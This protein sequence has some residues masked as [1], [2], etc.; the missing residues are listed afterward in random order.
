MNFDQGAKC[1]QGTKSVYNPVFR[2][3]TLSIFRS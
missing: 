2:Q 3:K 1:E